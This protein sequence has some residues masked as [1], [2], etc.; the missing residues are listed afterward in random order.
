[1]CY[2]LKKYFLLIFAVTSL[3]FSEDLVYEYTIYE[4][5]NL[6]SFPVISDNYDINYFFSSENNNL[7]SNTIV[8]DYIISLISEGELTFKDGDDWIGSLDEINSQ[9]GYWL[10]SEQD[11]SFLMISEKVQSLGV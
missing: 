5:A 7:F 3:V 9:K 6:I 11:L 8:S 10:I 4:G 2:K 1:M